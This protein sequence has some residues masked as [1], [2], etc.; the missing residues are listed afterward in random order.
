MKKF[1]TVFIIALLAFSIGCSPKK[2]ST[3]PASPSS[4]GIAVAAI[5]S[6]TAQ[7]VV[8]STTSGGVSDATVKINGSTVPLVSASTGGYGASFLYA[9]G[10]SISLS[11]TSPEG[12]ASAS[13][14]IPSST[15]QTN[16]S[17]SGAMTGSTMTLSNP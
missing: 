2:S 6:T 16:V 14:N 8:I 15:G 17:I 4:S 1:F 13:G 11:I 5:I 12:N 10:A 9:A 7:S 3:T